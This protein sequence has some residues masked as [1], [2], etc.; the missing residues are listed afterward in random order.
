MNIQLPTGMTISISYYDYLFVLKDEDMYSFYQECI[1]DNL[2]SFIE[3]PWHGSA[4][5]GRVNYEEPIIEE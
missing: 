1:A 2:G 5:K 4:E 3:D